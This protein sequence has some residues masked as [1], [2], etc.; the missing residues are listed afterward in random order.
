MS[1]SDWKAIVQRGIEILEATHDGDDL[2]PEHLKLIEMA[3]NDRLNEKG[4]AAFHALYEQV[5]AGYRKPWF[6]EI[7]HLTIDH[8]GYV[9]WKDQHVEHYDLPWAF[10]EAAKIEARELAQRCILL[11]RTGYEVDMGNTVWRWDRLVE[12]SRSGGRAP[13]R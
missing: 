7:E 13:G 3:V 10:S 9:F 5:Q 1:Q 12:D 8:E 4:M 6:H 11:E 2:S